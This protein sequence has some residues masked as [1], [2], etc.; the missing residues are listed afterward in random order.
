VTLLFFDSFREKIKY[1]HPAF[2][3]TTPEGL[4]SRLNFFITMYET[5]TNIKLQ[6]PNNLAF[7]RA[8]VCI[9][10]IGDFIILKY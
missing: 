4:N 6:G 7:G 8:P 5:R 2:H 9:L 3:S 1:F 10:R